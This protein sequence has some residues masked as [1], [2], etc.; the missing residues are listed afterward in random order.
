MCVNDNQKKMKSKFKLVATLFLVLAY[1]KSFAQYPGKP[2]CEGLKDPNDSLACMAKYADCTTPNW[3]SGADRGACAAED[4]AKQKG[5][6]ELRLQRL[7]SLLDAKTNSKLKAANAAYDR[8]VQ[9]QCAFE[10]SPVE[11]GSQYSHDYSACAYSFKE[12]RLTDYQRIYKN[13]LADR[14]R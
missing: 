6:Q 8:F 3:L 10:A 12:K 13:F 1:G 2:N 14:N 7:E 9:A 4:S 5:V 11:G